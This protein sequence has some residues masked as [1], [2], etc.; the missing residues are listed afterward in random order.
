MANHIS[1]LR[2]F[3]RRTRLLSCARQRLYG[4]FVNEASEYL[5]VLIWFIRMLHTVHEL[6]QPSV[7]HDFLRDFHCGQ[8][9]LEDPLYVIKSDD[10]HI[11]GHAQSPLRKDRAKITGG[12]VIRANIRCGRFPSTIVTLFMQI[13]KGNCSQQ[14][15][16]CQAYVSWI[17][18]RR[19]SILFADSKN[20]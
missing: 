15:E 3:T 6:L 8:L 7:S 10:A 12:K 9:R 4:A 18:L 2:F 16:I 5:N 19:F 20:I 13:S 17:F 14:K 11:V 1:K